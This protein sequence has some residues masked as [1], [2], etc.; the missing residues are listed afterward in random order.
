MFIF[1][2]GFFRNL[3]SSN[4]FFYVQRCCPPLPPF[5]SSNTGTPLSRDFCPR[6]SP[7]HFGRR[8]YLSPP[9]LLSSS[10]MAKSLMRPPLSLPL[11]GKFLLIGV[12]N[13]LPEFFLFL[14]H[15]SNPESILFFIPPTPVFITVTII[16]FCS[17]A[18]LSRFFFPLSLPL[19]LFPLGK[20]MVS[21]L[22]FFP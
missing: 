11:E 19:T 8:C 1:Q 21:L 2:V 14:P 15:F 18:H 12:S 5:F 10:F 6:F 22:F 9:P 16:H 3:N 4:F 13:T 20:V 17:P 7:G